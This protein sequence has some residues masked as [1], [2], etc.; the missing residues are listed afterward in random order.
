[1][2]IVV[3]PSSTQ[4][5]MIELQVEVMLVVASSTHWRTIESNSGLMI[6]V[7]SLKSE[8]NKTT[9]RTTSPLSIVAPQNA[10][11]VSDRHPSMR[12]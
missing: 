3:V 2:E 12:T 7:V 10:H 1:M 6:V 5:H 11:I 8:N 4:L 9:Q